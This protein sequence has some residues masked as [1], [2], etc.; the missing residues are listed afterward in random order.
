MYI[1]LLDCP[2]KCSIATFTVNSDYH[3]EA[4]ETLYILI[5][6]DQGVACKITPHPDFLWILS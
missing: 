5:I 3:W 1:G 6:I 4:M 2:Y